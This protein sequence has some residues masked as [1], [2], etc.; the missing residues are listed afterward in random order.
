MA[1]SSTLSQDDWLDSY[2][3]LVPNLEDLT[4]EVD[5]SSTSWWRLTKIRD[6]IKYYASGDL[7]A[8]GYGWAW[9]P[10]EEKITAIKEEADRK[11]I[12]YEQKASELLIKVQERINNEEPEEI[13]QIRH[14]LLPLLHDMMHNSKDLFLE[15]KHEEL[16]NRISQVCKLINKSE[17]STS[18]T[19]DTQDLFFMDMRQ[20]YT[21]DEFVKLIETEFNNDK[22]DESW[23]IL[24]HFLQHFMYIYDNYDSFTLDQKIGIHVLHKEWVLEAMFKVHSKNRF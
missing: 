10:S 1:F 14:Q 17:P 11:N 24:D 12:V 15:C 7:P 6:D 16:I 2:E 20:D 5:D 23:V 8:Y 9:N 19:L 21:R 13:Q 3:E 4:K 18:F 22:I